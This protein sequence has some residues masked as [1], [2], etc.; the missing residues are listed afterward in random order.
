MTYTAEDQIPDEWKYALAIGCPSHGAR[1]MDYDE[2]G[3]FCV[4]CEMLNSASANATR[5]TDDQLGEWA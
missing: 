5:W 4:T 2:A 1:A 3:P